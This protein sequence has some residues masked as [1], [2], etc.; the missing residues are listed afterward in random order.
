MRTKFELEQLLYNRF[1]IR[2]KVRAGNAKEGTD[3]LV[4]LD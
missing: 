1:D 4:T 3:W 2:K